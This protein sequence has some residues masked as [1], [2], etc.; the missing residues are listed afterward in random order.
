[1]PKIDTLD[2]E[3]LV[4]DE[5]LSE[6]VSEDYFG[7]PLIIGNRLEFKYIDRIEIANKN[8]ITT[9]IRIP[10]IKK[11]LNPNIWTLNRGISP[12]VAYFN[13]ITNKIYIYSFGEVYFEEQSEIEFSNVSSSYLAKIIIDLNSN[14]FGKATFSAIPGG[15]LETY[16]WLVCDEISDVW[17]Y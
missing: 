10:L 8:G 11:L 12:L 4:I 9:V 5:V 17:L 1:M 7:W 3:A 14:N 13:K 2:I 16:G 6:H 15:F